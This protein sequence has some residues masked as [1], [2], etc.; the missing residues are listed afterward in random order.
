MWILKFDIAK[1]GMCGKAFIGVSGMRNVCDNCRDE[2]QE[3]Y[4]K[5]R[6]IIRYSPDRQLTIADAA[7]ILHV[8]ERKIHHLVDNGLVQIVKSKKFLNLPG[9]PRGSLPGSLPNS[10]RGSKDD[11]I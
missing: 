4:E 7:S 6:A 8:E 5:L 3:L 10:F 9:E 11:F 2:E 1:C